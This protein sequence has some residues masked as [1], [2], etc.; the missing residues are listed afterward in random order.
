MW[1]VRLLRIAMGVGGYTN[2]KLLELLDV[3]A[4]Q[5]VTYCNGCGW[6]NGSNV[7]RVTRR[8]GVSECYV[9]QWVW[10]GKRIQRY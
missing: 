5:I 9:L 8:C 2:P 1:R 3:V 6:V 10:V 4:C 7:I